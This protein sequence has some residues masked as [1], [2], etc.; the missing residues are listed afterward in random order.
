MYLTQEQCQ[1]LAGELGW[2][3]IEDPEGDGQVAFGSPIDWTNPR[4]YE[5]G[6]RIEF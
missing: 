2:K 1:D 3:W 4:R 6:F 5:V